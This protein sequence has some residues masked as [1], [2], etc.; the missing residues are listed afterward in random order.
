MAILLNGARKPGKNIQERAV[1][2]LPLFMYRKSL[3]VLFCQMHQPIFFWG[4]SELF[5]EC[6][7]EAGVI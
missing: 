4:Y 5:S 2:W 1:K 7:V 3:Y 6:P